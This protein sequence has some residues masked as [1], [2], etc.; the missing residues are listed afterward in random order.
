MK[1]II[2]LCL[3]LSNVFISNAQDGN[4]ASDKPY[5]ADLVMG[6]YLIL[7]GTIY[8]SVFLRGIR[9]GYERNSGLAYGIEYIAGNQ[10]DLKG[11]L[12]TTHSAFGYIKYF[13]KKN[14]NSARFRPYMLAGGGF[15]EFKDFSAD[16]L[17]VAFYL[18]AG[19]EMNFNNTFKGFLEPRYVNLGTMDAD[20]THQLGVMWGIRARF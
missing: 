5:Y 1:K 14:D 8:E 10:E 17:G 6:P 13:T 3:L 15:F 20:G 18:G 12:G 2:F 19:T 7:D 4:I 9:I 11:E 16:V